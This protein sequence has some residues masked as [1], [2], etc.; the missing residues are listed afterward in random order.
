MLAL[1]VLKIIGYVDWS[2]C[3]ITCPVWLWLVFELIRVICAIYLLKT[4]K[5]KQIQPEKR[6]SGFQMRLDKMKEDQER[7]REEMKQRKK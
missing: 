6:R 7:I 5:Y 4:R 2:W 1:A 3:L